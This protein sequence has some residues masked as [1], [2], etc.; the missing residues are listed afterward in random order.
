MFKQKRLVPQGTYAVVRDFLSSHSLF[1]EWDRTKSARERPTK[2]P[3]FNVSRRR[4]YS[5]STRFIYNEIHTYVTTRYGA[6]GKN[7]K[8]EKNEQVTDA[9]TYDDYFTGLPTV[10]SSSLIS[11]DDRK[12]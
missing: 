6:G 3:T 8:K 2:W 1:T 12:C 10:R 9:H 7:K 4:K 5:E 11:S